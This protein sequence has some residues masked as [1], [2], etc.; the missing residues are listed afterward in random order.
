MN[1]GK[2]SICGL[3]NALKWNKQRRKTIYAISDGTNQMI[4]KQFG[5]E[6]KIK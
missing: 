6:Y 4:R 3:T 1:D 2:G 5:F